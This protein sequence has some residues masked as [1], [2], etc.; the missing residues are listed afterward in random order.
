MIRQANKFDAEAIVQMLKSYREQAPTQFLRDA[1]NRVHIDK[2]LA[3]IFAGAG[4]ILLAEKDEQI[5]GMVIAAQ[6]PNI[7]NPDVSQ[8]SEIAFWLDEA[9]RGGK[10]AHRL[11][12]AYI[13]QCEEWKQ[14]NRIQFFS[15]SKM[16]N[17]PDLSYDKFGFEKLEETWIK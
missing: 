15:I 7:W 10:L 14:E 4:F 17:S 6:H 2:L 13:Q 1:N 16:N 8:V 12:H 5:V 9:H 3:N 11:L